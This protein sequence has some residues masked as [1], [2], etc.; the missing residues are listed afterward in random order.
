MTAQ[1]NMTILHHPDHEALSTNYY[2]LMF[3]EGALFGR[4]TEVA[5]N[6]LRNGNDGSGNTLVPDSMEH[7]IIQKLAENNVVR[8]MATVIHT[9]NEERTIPLLNSMSEA[10]WLPDGHT[11]SMAEASVSVLRLKAHKLGIMLRISSELANDAGV[12]MSAF[13]ADA[14]ARQMAAA[15]ED[16]FLNGNGVDR[17]LGILS[18]NGAMVGVTAKKADSITAD[19]LLALYHSLDEPYRQRAVFMMHEDTANALRLLKYENGRYLWREAL[20][21]QP[22]MLLGRPAYVSRFMPKMAAG[23]KPVLFSDL[24]QYWIADR[25]NRSLRRYDEIFAD[26]G[27]IGFSLI[28][29][30]DGKLLI[31]EAV[32]VVRMA[33]GGGDGE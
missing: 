1:N 25:G 26:R 29:R 22:D 7:R 17:P 30:I 33:E 23:A 13:L 19:E 5:M 16:A 9:D 11:L 15:E 10:Q 4:E 27:E 20:G 31:P 3:R 2:E 32:K 12:D 21:G 24:S 28:E 18:G 8:R 14:F 6:E